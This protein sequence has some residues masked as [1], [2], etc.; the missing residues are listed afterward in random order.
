MAIGSLLLWLGDPPASGGAT[1]LLALDVAE[2]YDHL[3]LSPL[4]EDLDQE[5]SVP[6]WLAGFSAAWF[7]GRAGF[8]PRR[9]PVHGPRPVFC[10]VLRSRREKPGR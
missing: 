9:D 4:L 5:L 8:R 7:P 10:V 1:A 3:D 6:P 2:A